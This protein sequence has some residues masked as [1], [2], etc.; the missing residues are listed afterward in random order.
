MS[1]KFYIAIV[2]VFLSVFLFA[3]GSCGRLT[4]KY[5]CNYEWEMGSRQR[6][7]QEQYDACISKGWQYRGAQIGSIV[8]IFGVLALFIKRKPD[9]LKIR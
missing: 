6:L 8:L 7:N 3:W 1:L 4:T 5:D 9:P 2:F